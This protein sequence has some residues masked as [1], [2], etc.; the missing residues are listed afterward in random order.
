LNFT[1]RLDVV[2]V[3]HTCMGK[4]LLFVCV[5]YFSIWGLYLKGNFDSANP[6]LLDT[7]FSSMCLPTYSARSKLTDREKSKK[8]SKKP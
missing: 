6:S 2:C 5:M 4:F 3:L 1:S 8:P 7:V